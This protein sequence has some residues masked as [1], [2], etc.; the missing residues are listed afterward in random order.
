MYGGR[1]RGVDVGDGVELR[2]C[3]GVDNTA[4]EAV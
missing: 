4:Q 1:R 3:A 2:V